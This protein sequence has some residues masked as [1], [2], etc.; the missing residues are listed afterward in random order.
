MKKDIIEVIK[1]QNQNVETKNSGVTEE[2]LDSYMQTQL[3]LGI[4]GMT[5]VYGIGADLAALLHSMK[6]G[7]AGDSLLNLGAMVPGLGMFAGVKKVDDLMYLMKNTG[8]SEKEALE[9]I[10]KYQ[11][12]GGN[13][14]V[15]PDKRVV[16]ASPQ[17]IQ[18]LKNRY[19]K[20]ARDQIKSAEKVIEEDL[21]LIKTLKG[22]KG[23]NSKDII[24]I[25]KKSKE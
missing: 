4:A 24:D 14:P 1:N 3:G 9:V 17:D 15:M 10:N 12:S 22:E 11:K 5:P 13:T 18:T 8:M 16:D 20:D 23:F 7:K 2:A 6:H 19:G 25:I 21:D